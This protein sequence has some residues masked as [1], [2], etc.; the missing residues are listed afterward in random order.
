MKVR[1]QDSVKPSTIFRDR[2][3]GLIGDAANRPLDHYDFPL[4]ADPF[5]FA[6][7]CFRFWAGTTAANLWG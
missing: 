2:C 7:T 1:R 4:S 5:A 3:N 6:L